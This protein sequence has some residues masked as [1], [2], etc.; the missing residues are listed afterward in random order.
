MYSKRHLM[1]K[2]KEEREKN[3]QTLQ[4]SVKKVMKQ[5]WK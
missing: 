5:Q 1:R 3:L 4:T 2:V